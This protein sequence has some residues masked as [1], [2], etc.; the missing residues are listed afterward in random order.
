MSQ[1]VKP[2]TPARAGNTP[3]G[4]AP[5]KGGSGRPR[6]IRREQVLSIGMIV[7]MAIAALARLFGPL[8]RHLR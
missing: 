4:V 5:K 2:G 8:L 6:R 1:K 3:K 7:L